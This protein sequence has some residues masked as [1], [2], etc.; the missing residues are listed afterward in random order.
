MT[1]LSRSP[2][3][4]VL[5][6]LGIIVVVVGCGP[7]SGLADPPPS[8]RGAGRVESSGRMSV[9]RATHT[10][11]RIAGGKVLIAGG[12]AQDSCESG[13]GAAT[14]ELYDPETGVF[15]RAGTLRVPRVGHTATL[16]PNGK[17]LLAGGWSGRNPVNS[18]E[19]YDPASGRFS[20]TGPM[21]DRR[22]GHTATLLPNG[23]VLIAGGVDGDHHLRTAELY[24]P[25]SGA[26][27]SAGEMT[28]PRAAHAA[29]MLSGGRVLL[30]GGESGRGE[31][32]ASADIYDSRTGLFKGTGRMAVARHKLAAIGIS[33]G[34]VLILGGSDARDGAGQ[35]ASTELFNPETGAFEVAADMSAKRFKLI[36]AVVR[37]EDG[38]VLVGGGAER[39]EIYDPADGKFRIAEGGLDASR[40]FAT[41]TLLKNGD[42]L[43]AGGYDPR[44]R[45]TD[46][47]WVYHAPR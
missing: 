36:D 32:L 38:K 21:K 18:A 23:E 31:I 5:K 27:T 43:I 19:L 46:R 30:A 17:V 11:T 44:I 26:F 1:D 39:A 2:C 35:Y 41:A 42:V 13:E 28:T 25:K 14:A 3:G 37:L 7:A 10:A 12:C 22:G 6:A 8:V 20:L 24:D 33:N 45:P 4:A 29:A 15:A 47:T 9:P 16:L 40:S 34:K